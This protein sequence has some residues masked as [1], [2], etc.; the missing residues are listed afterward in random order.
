MATKPTVY[1]L[2][3]FHDEAIEHAETLFSLILPSDPQWADWRA[4]AKY[5]LVRS[6]Y[7]T[8]ADLD[9]APHLLAIGKQGVGL[10][11][12]D[13][14]AC[15]ARGIPV[16]NTP[17]L[18]ASAV[19]ELVLALTMCVARQIRPILLRQDGGEAVSRNTCSGMSLRGKTIGII[20]FGNIGKAVAQLFQAAFGAEVVV[21][22]PMSRS[23]ISE[24]SYTQV[25]SL[26][27]LLEVADVVSVHVPLN[28]STRD[29]ISFNELKMMKPTSILINTARGGIVNEEDLARALEEEVIFGA[30]IDV[31]TEEPPTLN[32]YEGLWSSGFKN[33]VSLPHIGASTRET[34]VACGKGAIDNLYQYIQAHEP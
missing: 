19:A 23:R 18:N 32:K 4:N 12:I 14:E 29:L 9:Q 22:R 34:Q 25:A 15:A 30:G 27:E 7:V 2:D 26:E 16:L 20:G 1:M 21:F 11:K 8:T 28:P 10:D 33:I 3:W 31:H 17:G 13:V 24:S 6:T 5:L